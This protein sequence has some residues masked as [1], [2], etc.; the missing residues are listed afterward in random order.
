MK[1]L[2]I[3]QTITFFFSLN[4]K[5]QIFTRLRYLSNESLYSILDKFYETEET[6]QEHVL[7]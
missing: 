3:N 6:K 1:F 4:K 7:L 2:E 5:L